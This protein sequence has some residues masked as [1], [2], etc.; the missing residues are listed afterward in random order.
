MQCKKKSVD[1]VTDLEHAAV[2][3]AL[4]SADINDGRVGGGRV[5]QYRELPYYE[6]Q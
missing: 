5:Q 2:S 4:P 3:D 6:T 1:V